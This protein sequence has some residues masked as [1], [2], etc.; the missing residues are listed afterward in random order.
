M[1]KV[2]T[3]R[4]AAKRFRKTASGKFKMKHAFMRHQLTHKSRKRK[5]NLRQ[6]GIVSATDTHRLERL[7]P[8]A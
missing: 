8:Y 7:L 4:G 1:P 3:K 5:R 2:K 6:P